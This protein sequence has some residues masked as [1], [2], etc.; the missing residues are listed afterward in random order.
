MRR[1]SEFICSSGGR[2]KN[3]A[4]IA[5]LAIAERQRLICSTVDA[6]TA[7]VG[8][9]LSTHQRK[10]ISARNERSRSRGVRSG[11]WA[12]AGAVLLLECAEG[13]GGR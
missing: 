13:E 10:T 7:R 11:Q 5:S 2:G 9:E 1:P 3:D 6:G 4:G 8:A 12:R